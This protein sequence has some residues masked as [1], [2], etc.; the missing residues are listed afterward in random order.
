MITW[1]GFV[2]RLSQFCVGK[3]ASKRVDLA[4]EAKNKH[5]WAF[6]RL[7]RLLAD[8]EDACALFVQMARPVAAGE[9]MRI[10][11]LRLRELATKADAVSRDFFSTIGQLQLCL[12]SYD[13][14]L[15]VLIGRLPLRR[16]NT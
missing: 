4:P 16:I 9:K 11:D 13:P 5:A 10:Y 15:V 1:A 12:M 6:F 8:L 14:M 3:I 7:Y 2:G